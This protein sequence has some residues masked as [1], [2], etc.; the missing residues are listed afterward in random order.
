VNKTQIKNFLKGMA[1]SQ[2]VGM[3]Q[4]KNVAYLRGY[5]TFGYYRLINDRKV[6]AARQAAA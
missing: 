6:F 3:A 1:D 4:S 5:D 2:N